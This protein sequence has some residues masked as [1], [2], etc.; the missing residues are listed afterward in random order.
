MKIQFLGA[1]GEVTGSKYL[2]EMDLAQRS[3]RVIV[4]YGMFQGVVRRWKKIKV[5]ITYLG[6]RSGL[7]HIDPCPHRPQRPIA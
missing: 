6:I 2:L 5:R 4:D 7:R 1:A 3:R